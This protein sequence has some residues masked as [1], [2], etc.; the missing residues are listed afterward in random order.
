MP[1][2]GERDDEQDE[3]ALD[4]LLNHEAMT[5]PLGY[6]AQAIIS[7]VDS[8]KQGAL[9]MDSD[10]DYILDEGSCWIQVGNL[11]VHVKKEDEGVA[12]DVYPLDDENE[13]ALTSSYTFF[14]DAAEDESGD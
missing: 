12:I 3:Q 1:P 6:A 8:E 13:A 10:G 4:A 7:A 2:R 14:T 9:R 5:D 11:S